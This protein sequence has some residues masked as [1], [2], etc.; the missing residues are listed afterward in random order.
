MTHLMKL[1]KTIVT[2]LFL[3]LITSVQA[4]TAN[5]KDFVKKFDRFLESNTARLRWTNPDTIGSYARPVPIPN[6]MDATKTHVP[7][8]GSG[9]WHYPNL[10]KVYDPETSSDSGQYY[11]QSRIMSGGLSVAF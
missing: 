6:A 4:Q 10:Q 9:L 11:P 2:I 1:F 5:Q 3:G 7:D 8:P